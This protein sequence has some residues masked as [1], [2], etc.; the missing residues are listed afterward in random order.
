MPL[1]IQRTQCSKVTKLSS[2]KREATIITALVQE[3]VTNKL[4]FTW[5]QSEIVRKL[6]PK[7]RKNGL[8]IPCSFC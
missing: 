4:I 7:L 8:K 5:N 2:E 3:V 1:A 6:T